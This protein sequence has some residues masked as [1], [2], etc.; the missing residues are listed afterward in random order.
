MDDSAL[1]ENRR[2]VAELCQLQ[3]YQYLGRKEYAQ[4]LVEEHIAESD[5]SFLLREPGYPDWNLSYVRNFALLLARSMGLERVLYMDEDIRVP[6][7]GL[8][9]ELFSLLTDV[10]FAGAHVDGMPDQ[11]I[12]GHIA[13]DVGVNN[14]EMLSGGFLAF[15]PSSVTEYFVNIYNEDWIW[16]FLQILTQRHAKHGSVLQE[17]ADRFDRYQSKV[18]FQEHGELIVDGLVDGHANGSYA[19]LESFDFWAR[20]LLE[21]DE[22]LQDLYSRSVAQDRPKYV[23]ILRH[24]LTHRQV[25]SPEEITACCMSYKTNRIAFKGLLSSFR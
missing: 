16:L 22:Y 5:F 4:F 12:L 13:A 11:S 20:M 1:P 8:I 6:D 14:P 15:N 21:R 7:I 18:L 2:A 24:L 10:S 9:D 17:T 19:E 23:S 25:S 3:G